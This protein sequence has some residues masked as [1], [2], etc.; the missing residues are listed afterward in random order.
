M[1]TQ[2]ITQ[3]TP[4]QASP[5]GKERRRSQ[6]LPHIIE[7]FI[8]SPTATDERTEV[9]AVNLSR[10]GVAFEASQPLPAG[11]FHL[12]EIGLGDQKLMSEIRVISC[13][14]SDDGNWAI[15]AEFC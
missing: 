8:A 15:G 13:T 11:S 2:T 4:K 9:T 12:I 10:H 1:G 3:G 14:K 5:T 7:A 6:R